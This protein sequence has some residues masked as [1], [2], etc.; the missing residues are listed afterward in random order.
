MSLPSSCPDVTAKGR[1]PKPTPLQPKDGDAV[2]QTDHIATRHTTPR[3]TEF[4]SFVTRTNAP[5]GVDLGPGAKLRFFRKKGADRSRRQFERSPVPERS[6]WLRG[7][8]GRGGADI[9]RTRSFGF[10]CGS[11]RQKGISPRLSYNKGRGPKQNA[12]VRVAPSRQPAAL[13]GRA[14]QGK[15]MLPGLP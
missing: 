5:A 9:D 11:K 13:V 12:Q 2:F 10:P 1:R 3:V 7:Y 4:F 15:T 8:V 14:F 6:S